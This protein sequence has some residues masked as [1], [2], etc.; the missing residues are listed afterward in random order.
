M[1]A[2]YIHTSE[3]LDER[4]LMVQWGGYLDENKPHP[5]TA[6]DF[7]KRIKEGCC[8]L[9]YILFFLFSFLSCL[10]FNLLEIGPR[11]LYS[12]KLTLVAIYGSLS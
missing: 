8:I 1:R 4:Q 7:A 10:S 5:I 11:I 6:F 3:H 2:E 9:H 12:K